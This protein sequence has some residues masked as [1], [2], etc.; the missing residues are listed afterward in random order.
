MQP[1]PSLTYKLTEPSAKATNVVNTSGYAVS[2]STPKWGLA[3]KESSDAA[4]RLPIS[5]GVRAKTRKRNDRA[6]CIFVVSS[7]G[8]HPAAD[9]SQVWRELGSVSSA[10]LTPDSDE[11]TFQSVTSPSEADCGL[12]FFDE[13][14]RNGFIDAY[15][16]FATR[17]FRWLGFLI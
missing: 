5:S 8:A 2:T 6:I 16:V 15:L 12:G 14:S 4:V 1:F 9:L 13:P 17:S 3:A 11:S 7:T 10:A